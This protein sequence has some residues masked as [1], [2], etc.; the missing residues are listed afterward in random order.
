[1]KQNKKSTKPVAELKVVANLKLE[2]CIDCPFHEVQSDPDPD[3]WFCDD[4]V[5]VLCTLTGPDPKQGPWARPSQRWLH[6]AITQS[7]RPDNV[8]QEAAVPDWCPLKKL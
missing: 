7:C 1:M 5:A 4:D 2:N 8:K 6:F 3:D